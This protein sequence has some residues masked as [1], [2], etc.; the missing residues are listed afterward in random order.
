M[1]R[2]PNPWAYNQRPPSVNPRVRPRYTV[3]ICVPCYN[4]PSDIVFATCEAALALR[5]EWC[6]VHVYMLDDGRN[7]EREKKVMMMGNDRFVYL[8]RNKF[9]GVPIHGKAGNINSALKFHIFAKKPPT[10]NDVVIIFDADMKAHPNFLNHV[11]P[12]LEEDPMTALVQT[13]QHFFN[14][15]HTGDVFNHQNSTFFFGVQTGLDAWRATVCCGTNFAVRAAPLAAVGWFPTE[16]ITEDFLLSLKLAAAGHVCRYHAA[17][18]STGE[19]PEDLRQIF[20]QRERWCT[21]CFQVFFHRE[22]WATLARLRWPQKLCFLNAPVGYVCSIVTLPVWLLVPALSLYDVHPVRALTPELV[23]LWCATYALMV[24]VCEAMPRRLNAAYCGFVASKANAAFWW[25]YAAALGA[26]L[27]GLACPH[28]KATFQVTEKR[29]VAAAAAAAAAKAEEEAE[30]EEDEAPARDSSLRDVVYHHAVVSGALLVMAGGA[31]H[32]AAGGDRHRWERPALVVI[33]AA[34][35][36]INALP[37]AMVLAYAHGPHSFEAHAAVVR[38]AW[39][40]HALL[41][42]TIACAL[43][44]AAAHE[45]R[46][47]ELVDCAAV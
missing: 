5:H 36:C 15:D 29:S 23:L 19:A 21:G 39:W 18:V 17:V 28:R 26:A 34:W 11:M 14:V 37:A 16:S 31:L 35:L 13:P 45:R 22:M 32:R 20:K 30:E 38:G 47:C 3:H 40:A 8:A 41:T 12:Y 24:A 9:P 33:S 25:C 2:F 46:A 44:L 7:L 6:K 27:V 1:I 42:L 4:E 10:E 43:L